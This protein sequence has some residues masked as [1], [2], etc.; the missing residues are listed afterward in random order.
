M[1]RWK[2]YADTPQAY[3]DVP[4]WEAERRANRMEFWIEFATAL[5]TFLLLGALL[6]AFVWAVTLVQP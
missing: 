4:H 1:T 6:V 5:A 3:G 2:K